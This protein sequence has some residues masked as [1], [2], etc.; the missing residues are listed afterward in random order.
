MLAPDRTLC[1]IPSKLPGSSLT[2][3]LPHADLHLQRVPPAPPL[4][5][6]SSFVLRRPLIHVLL[7]TAASC[8]LRALP[9]TSRFYPR[10][11]PYFV[12]SASDLSSTPPHLK[13][14][15]LNTL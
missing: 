5:D 3:P 11:F 8:I 4:P 10:W 7:L 13:T 1:Q 9:F 2:L 6:D 14:S 15:P 12:L